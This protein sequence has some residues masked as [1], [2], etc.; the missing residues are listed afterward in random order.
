MLN[1]RN[2]RI[3]WRIALSDFKLRYNNSVLGYLWTLIKPLV[4]FGVLYVVFSFFMR[5]PVENYALNLLLGVILWN[6]F[7]EATSIGLQAFVSKSNLI[8]K[9][10][11]PRYLIVLASTTTSLLTLLLNLLIFFAFLAYSNLGFSW[12]ML[13]LPFYLLLMYFFTLGMAFMLSVLY[14]SFRDLSHIWEVL[15]QIFFWLTPV[16]Y[17]IE[18]VPATYHPWIFLNPIAGIIESL[19]EIFIHNQ[20]LSL[21]SHLYIVFAVTLCFAVGLFIFNKMQATLAEKI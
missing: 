19:R 12:L 8:T 9:I 20:T 16:V 2:L 11:F 18:V 10:Y 21:N 1:Q 3:F 15:L 5:F 4:L 17:T 6:F 13:S 14:V 7:V